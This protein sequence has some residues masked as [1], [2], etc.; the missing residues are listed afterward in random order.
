M[1]LS[2]PRYKEKARLPG[3][4][5]RNVTKNAAGKEVGM[6][7]EPDSR[8]A[9]DGTAE[10]PGVPAVVTVAH[11]EGIGAP[12]RFTR[13]AVIKR[14]GTVIGT[15]MVAGYVV[16]ELVGV[17]AQPAYAQASP[18]PKPECVRPT[19]AQICADAGVVG[20][21][22][23]AWANSNAHNFATRHERG[24]W[25]IQRCDVATLGAIILRCGA[26]IAGTRAGLAPG[27]DPSGA[28]ERAVAFF[29]T[30]PNPTP[31]EMGNAWVLGPSAADTAWHAARAL[32]GL[33]YHHSVNPPPAAGYPVP[34]G[35][36][37][38]AY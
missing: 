28:N 33:L 19:A 4:K 21:M 16:P 18:P 32:I 3:S 29:H 37:K 12:G 13:R 2:I 30:H 24:F 7:G 8:Q 35:S 15:L 34:P 1:A 23:T 27:G 10:E 22:N 38:V 36:T 9:G 17:K 25:I 11:E 14:G 31:D 26:E 20:C 6:S 5:E